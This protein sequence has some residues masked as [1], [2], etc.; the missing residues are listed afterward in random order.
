ML[1]AFF[2]VA[3]LEHDG[4]IGELLPQ[5]GDKRTHSLKLA[6][7]IPLLRVFHVAADGVE[8]SDVAIEKQAG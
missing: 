6:F 4:H 1:P 8:V 2:V 7:E 5:V 3:N